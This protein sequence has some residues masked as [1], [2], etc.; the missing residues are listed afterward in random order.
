MFIAHAEVKDN[1]SELSNF[2]VKDLD[3]ILPLVAFLTKTSL[4]GPKQQLEFLAKTLVQGALDL[5]SSAPIEKGPQSYV[6]LGTPIYVA[7]DD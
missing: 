2:S 4:K 1:T 7:I 5:L 3:E 6:V